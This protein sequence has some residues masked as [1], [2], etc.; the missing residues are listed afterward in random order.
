MTTMTITTSPERDSLENLFDAAKEYGMM[1]S[2]FSYDESGDLTFVLHF[3]AAMTE[4][5]FLE[6]LR[7]YDL[8]EL[9]DFMPEFAN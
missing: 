1:F 6:M 9:S 2:D 7:G 8:E 5:T 4:A 3:P